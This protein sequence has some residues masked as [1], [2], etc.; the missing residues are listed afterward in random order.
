MDPPTIDLPVHLR[1]V[2]IDQFSPS[3]LRHLA[4]G[5]EANRPRMVAR[6]KLSDE[7][8]DELATMLLDRK[9]PTIGWW[10]RHAS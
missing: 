1:R 6:R 8:L 2:L 10:K 4:S 3:T 7:S 9:T 5:M